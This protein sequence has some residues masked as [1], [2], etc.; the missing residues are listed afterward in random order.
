[1]VPGD[2]SRTTQL[3]QAQFAKKLYTQLDEN[4]LGIRLV[5]VSM[6]ILEEDKYDILLG[7]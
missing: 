3:S 2:S 4:Q 6:S 5:G 1:M 7:I